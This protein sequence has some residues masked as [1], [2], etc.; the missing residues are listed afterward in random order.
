LPCFF[1]LFLAHA[2]G[3]R[4]WL[5]RWAVCPETVLFRPLRSAKELS[6]ASS[7]LG[8]FDQ[9]LG[10]VHEIVSEHRGTNKQ[11]EALSALRQAALH[12]AA[13]HQH[14]DA[15]LMEPVGPR[16][17]GAPASRACSRNS[18]MRDSRGHGS[19]VPLCRGRHTKRLMGPTRPISGGGQ[20]RG[21]G[22]WLTGTLPANTQNP[23]GP[24]RAC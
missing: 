18:G 2:G 24:W 6:I 21:L 13:A 15:P 22:A 1:V 8:A 3:A 4:D 14:R 23:S 20:S 16:S 19:G 17:C 11:F 12:A 5:Q 9:Q 10:D 7:A